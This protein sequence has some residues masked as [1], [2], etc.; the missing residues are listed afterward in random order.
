MGIDEDGNGAPVTRGNGE[1]VGRSPALSAKRRDAGFYDR[2]K[3]AGKIRRRNALSIERQF[4][5]Q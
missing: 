1:C 4:M 3:D 5:Q 2:I